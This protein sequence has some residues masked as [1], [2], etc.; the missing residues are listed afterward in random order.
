MPVHSTVNITYN[1]LNS[2]VYTHQISPTQVRIQ[3]VGEDT[4]VSGVR[5]RP[6]LPSGLEVP[7][8]VEVS[9]TL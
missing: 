7:D 1:P 8:T 3:I 2:K 6:L 4:Q 9:A 5:L